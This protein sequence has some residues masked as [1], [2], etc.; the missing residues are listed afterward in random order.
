MNSIS[1][2]LGFRDW[3]HYAQD[4]KTWRDLLQ[5]ELVVVPHK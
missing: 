5:Q 1:L 4:R 2:A 3:T